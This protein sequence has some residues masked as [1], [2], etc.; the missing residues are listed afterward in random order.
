MYGFKRINK[1]KN[2]LSFKLFLS[3][4]WLHKLPQ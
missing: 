3:S 2:L 4:L 1:N